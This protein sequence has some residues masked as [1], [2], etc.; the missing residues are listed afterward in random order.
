[1]TNQELYGFLP[2][3]TTIVRQRRLRLAGQVMRYDEAANK[4]LLWK[5]DGSP[6]ALGEEAKR[7][8]LQNDERNIDVGVGIYALFP[9]VNLTFPTPTMYYYLYRPRVIRPLFWVTSA[10][11]S[12]PQDSE[13]QYSDETEKRPRRRCGAWWVAPCCCFLTL[14]ATALL[15]GLVGGLVVLP[16]LGPVATCFLVVLFSV[17]LEDSMAALAWWCLLLVFGASGQ[18]RPIFFF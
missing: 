3:I 17:C 6:M 4:V 18:S 9:I 11:T 12:Y 15:L 10:F 8:H 1:M 16:A 13:S 14:L 2:R 5:P 7:D